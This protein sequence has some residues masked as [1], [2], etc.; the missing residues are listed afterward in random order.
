[1]LRPKK[2]STA[3]LAFST[4][5]QRSS[6]TVS[7]AGSNGLLELPEKGE[8]DGYEAGEIVQCV[9]IGDVASLA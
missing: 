4:G 5:S 8:R 3:L 1:M 9:I 6:R 2:G 7:L